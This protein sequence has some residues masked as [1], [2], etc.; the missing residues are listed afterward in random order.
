MLGAFCSF[1]SLALGIRYG[2]D[3]T[4]ANLFSLSQKRH[5]IGLDPPGESFWKYLEKEW[6]K[7]YTIDNAKN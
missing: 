3:Q 2:E 5:G 1:G 6:K 7:R 4:A